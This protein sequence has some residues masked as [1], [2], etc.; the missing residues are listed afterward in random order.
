MNNNQILF[1]TNHNNVFGSSVPDESGIYNV[2]VSTESIAKNSNNGNPMASMKYIVLDGTQKGKAIFD[3][4][5]WSN[6]SQE[7]HDLSIKR[8][9]TVLIASGCQ[10]GVAIHSIPEFVQMMNNQRFA[11]ETEWQKSDYNGNVYLTVTRYRQLLANGSQPDGKKRPASNSSTTGFT[12]NNNTP[13]SH[14]NSQQG[15]NP[16]GQPSP[17]GS[18]NNAPEVS[19]DDLPF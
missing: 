3:R 10:D 9:N 19:D 1:T 5:V 15:Y 18:N 2:A 7:A 12:Q 8:F 4:L 16:Q 6:S 13:Q 11:V 17:F 14:G